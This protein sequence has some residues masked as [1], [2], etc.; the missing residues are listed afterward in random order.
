MWIDLEAITTEVE[1]LFNSPW[2]EHVNQACYSGSWDVL[3]LYSKEEHVGA[4]P[5][6]QCFSIE[7]TDA[8]FTPLPAMKSLPALAL[9]L[10]QF[11]C[12]LKSVRLMRL[13]GGSKILPHND[14]Q[15]SMEY[16]EARIHV[17]I[18]G[19]DHVDFTVDGQR[20]PMMRGDVWY[21]NAHLVHSVSNL[22]AES[23]VNL[24][25]D[26]KVEDWLKNIIKSSEQKF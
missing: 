6:L 18:S 21:L 20:V 10:A 5:V 9:F 7:Q 2:Y 25:I 14:H 16:G 15:V 13:K 8:T 26:C 11:K 17:P 19:I 4:H 3:P 1:K 12:S 22:G 23:R 24:V